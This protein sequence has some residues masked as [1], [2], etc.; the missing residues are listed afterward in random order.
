MCR[1]AI[2]F[3]ASIR[4]IIEVP[5]MTKR[6]TP[7][8][9]VVLVVTAMIAALVIVGRESKPAD[10]FGTVKIV[11]TSQ[12]VVHEPITRTL[13]C[14][15]DDP[16][17]H[18]F[19]S[20]SIAM[21]A[22]KSGTF[23]AVGEPDNPLDGNP[24]PAARHC[25]DIDHGYGS[26]HTEEEA[27]VEFDKC[28]TAYQKYMEFAV[29]SA[30][31]L[32]N[33]DGSIDA[34]QTDLINFWGST[35]NACKFPDPQ[36]GN[37]GDYSAKCD[38]L[39][40]LGRA[41]HIYEDIWSHSN[42]GDFAAGNM[43]IGIKN[44][45]GLGNTQQPGFM[46]FPGPSTFPLPENFLSGCDDSLPL[47]SCG[48]LVTDP[49]SILLYPYNQKIE[50][51]TS[52]SMLNKDN[53][54]VSA[55]DC[56]ATDPLTDRGKITVDSKTN[57]QRA[58]TGACGAAR[59]AWS[60]LQ[61]ALVVKYGQPKAAKMIRAISDDHPTTDCTVGGSA[62]K[63]DGPPV[64]ERSSS[65]SVRITVKNVTSQPLACGDA[66]LDGG[67]WASYPPDSIDS[68]A[69]GVWV[70]QS[71]GFATGTEGRATF[72]LGYGDAVFT[73]RW[74]NPYIGSNDY[75]CT[76][77]QGYSCSRAGGSGNDSRV[78]FTFTGP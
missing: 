23:G 10:A 64:G 12:R 3:V 44:P 30:A 9:I 29:D 17:E 22:G 75:S 53:G 43:E 39:N 54:T 16:V 58:I 15:V 40:G 32:V 49:D 76:A 74:N 24:N 72:K 68:M 4:P 1:L 56:S 55:K 20:I 71:N 38:V 37:F 2:S 19:E 50:Q 51:R 70:T 36:K 52:H 6:L 14:N 13:A 47:N 60:D 67:E 45:V 27:Q 26:W 35:Y 78:T 34:A 18:C 31:K 8:S 59:R 42:W 33:T 25:D 77:P 57:F 21:L 69:S 65:R 7:A 48:R 5:T 73:V 61:N 28:L 62:A 11:G 46:S 41:L 63:A 66:I